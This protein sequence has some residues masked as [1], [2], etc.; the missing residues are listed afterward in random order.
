[1]NSLILRCVCLAS[2]LCAMTP[3]WAAISTEPLSGEA[4]TL[5]DRAYHAIAK[6]DDEAAELLVI[7][8]REIQPDSYQLAMLLLD[9]QMRRRQWD[10]AQKFADE[11]LTQLP[12]DAYLLANCGFI[13]Q[14]QKR[15]TEARNYFEAALQYPGLDGS[16]RLNVQKALDDLQ[17]SQAIPEAAL[18]IPASQLV[19]SHYAVLN[20]A[21]RWLNEHEDEKALAAF[22]TAFAM[23]P[24]TPGQYASAAYAAKNSHKNELSIE[25]FQLALDAD[26]ALPI[27]DQPFDAQ[28]V[29]TYRREI[30]QMNRSW[31]ATV[32][33]TFQHN[34]ITRTS[35]LNTLQGGAEVYWQPNDFA[36]N[37]D[38]HLFHVFAGVGETL[39][40]AQGG[41]TGSTT[42]QGTLGVRY[43]PFS[44]SGIMLVAQRLLPFRN[45][46]ANDTYLHAGYFDALGGELNVQKSNWKNWQYFVDA[47][48]FVNARRTY[49]TFEGNYGQA[50]RL[51][52]SSDLIIWTP[53][54][55]LAGEYDSAAIKPGAASIG[56]GI[57]LQYFLRE[58]MYNAP[59]SRLEI[60]MQYRFKLSDSNRSQGLLMRAMYV[61]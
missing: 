6:H 25:L 50:I 37:H 53:H 27:A 26:R 2:C 45:P 20:E 59:A 22:Q 33:L 46:G 56:P 14:F 51:N 52:H 28:Q 44:N 32:G 40:D 8:A 36:G 5:A 41:P 29:F 39:Y 13:S 10:V 58:N 7:K 34:A 57:K 35:T 30:Q 17:Y 61:Y 31:G 16:Q 55:A 19:V 47:G 23:Q 54:V 3:A 24:G 1:M 4:Y 12:R 48:Y 9:I 42:T 60:N 49:G 18:P 43:K 38:G 15:N 11:L 21:Y